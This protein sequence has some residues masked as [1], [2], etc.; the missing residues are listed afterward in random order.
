MCGDGYQTVLHCE[1]AEWEDYNYR[2][3]DDEPVYCK[4]EDEESESC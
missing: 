2:T 3:P 4:E 1:Y